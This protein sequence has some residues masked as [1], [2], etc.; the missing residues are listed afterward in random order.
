[1]TLSGKITTLTGLDGRLRTT[2]WH[3]LCMVYPPCNSP[4]GRER[5][6]GDARNG[7]GSWVRPSNVLEVKPMRAFGS[8]AA[9]LGQSFGPSEPRFP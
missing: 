2:A 5:P 6:G 7:S 9:I 1:M 8:G 3:L 4:A